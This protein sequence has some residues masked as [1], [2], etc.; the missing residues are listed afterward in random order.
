MNCT[1][2]GVRGVVHSDQGDHEATL[3]S[4]AISG[5]II[6]FEL[7][8]D[9]LPGRVHAHAS[10]LYLGAVSVR[11]SLDDWAY[12]GVFHVMQPVEIT[13]IVPPRRGKK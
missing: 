4:V 6:T 13:S 7:V 3:Q 11:V 1:A 9:V 10:T 8:T 2:T 5:P 12:D